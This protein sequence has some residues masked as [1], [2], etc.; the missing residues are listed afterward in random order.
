MRC[1]YSPAHLQHVPEHEVQHGESMPT[2]ETPARI[3][4]IRRAL[5]EDG[6][7]DLVPPEPHGIGPILAVHDERLVRFLQGAW[8]TWTEEKPGREPLADSVLHSRL[9][10][11]MEEATEPEGITGA[12][13]YWCF[14]SSTPLSPGFYVAAATSVEVALTTVDLILAGERIAYGM[15]RPPGHHAARAMFGGYCFFN[16][17]AVAAHYMVERTGGKVAVLDV[18]YHHG[19]GTQQIFYRRA[20]VFFASLHADPH[21]AY[22]L[23]TGF[24]DERGA[25]DGAGTT[26]NLPLGASCDGARYMEALD[27]VLDALVAFRPDAVIVSLGLDTYAKDPIADFGLNTE[28]FAEMGRRVAGIETPL[29]VVQE[30]GYHVPDLGSNALAWLDGARD[31]LGPL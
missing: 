1:V 7:F 9:R 30:G 16:N 29:A 23:F 31:P 14:D 18:D 12:L 25:G 24:W 8:D 13:G 21:F 5:E 10:E 2:F 3:E 27:S 6:S 26:L 28:D 15:C 19:N 11:G 4:T 20:D 22:P 17:A